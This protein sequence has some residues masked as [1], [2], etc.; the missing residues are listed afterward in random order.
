MVALLG[1]TPQLWTAL[2]AEGWR[3]L[4]YRLSKGPIAKWRFT[5]LTPDRLLIV[6]PDL[7]VAD[8][9]IAD[10]F[11]NSRYPLANTVVDT[12][13]GSPFQVEH[14]KAEWL[15]ELHGFRWL[16]HMNEAGTELHFANAR[17]LTS[18]WLS[19]HGRQIRD[20]AWDPEVTAMRVIAWLQHSNVVLQGA[21]LPFYRAFVKSLTTQVRYLRA[22]VGQIAHSEGRLRAR[23]AIAYASLSLPATPGTIR[24][25]ARRLEEEL[26]EQILPDGGHVSRNPLALLEILTDL[27]PLRQTYAN[28]STDVPA[29]LVSAIDRIFPALRALRHEDGSLARFNGV[30]ITEADRI[31]AVLRFD[32]NAGQPLLSGTHSG[33]QRLSMGCCAVIADAGKPPAG[34]DSAENFAG[35]LSFEMSS[36]RHCYIVNSGIDQ[37][38]PEEYRDLARLTAAHSAL[39]LNDT[40][41][42]RYTSKPWVKSWLGTTMI[43]G[44]T[45]VALER[46]DDDEA[47][48]FT[49]RHNGYAALFGLYHERMLRLSETGSL[50]EGRDRVTRSSGKPAAKGKDKVSVRFH[51]HPQIH[52]V[53]SGDGHYMLMADQDDSW[54]F[55]CDEVEPQLTES[56]FF[57]GL[58]GPQR[59]RQLLL[60]YSASDHPEVNWRFVRTGLGRWSSAH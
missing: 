48:S 29:G 11:Y 16:R 18:D 51:L 1:D 26:D 14:A 49:A 37:S 9:A 6:P 19:M 35:C 24:S 21:E 30:G 33:Y 4:R 41:S 58:T 22:M 60:E 12:N 42:C 46:A 34:I 47:Q 39:V 8:A 45:A 54:V 13:G 32:D 43:A 59:T 50:L 57:G 44:P 25:A 27:V 52:V 15:R 28:Q 53:R 36:G 5:G 56:I 20:P 2:A 40:S 38:G 3:R 10:Y 17:S 23:I 7:R 55:V 31:A